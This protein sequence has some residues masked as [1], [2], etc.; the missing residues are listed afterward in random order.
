LHS[1][2]LQN[3]WER[4]T[5]LFGCPTIKLEE[6]RLCRKFEAIYGMIS[7]HGP[8]GILREKD[9]GDQL[10]RCALSPEVILMGSASM[11]PL[12]ASPFY[13]LCLSSLLALRSRLLSD[14][15]VWLT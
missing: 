11:L 2:S 9:D 8:G 6:E 15:R 12:L 3:P 4:S 14:A 1:R 7:L 10:Q 13:A 5:C